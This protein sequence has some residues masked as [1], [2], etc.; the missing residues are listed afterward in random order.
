MLVLSTS[1]IE[2]NKKRFLFFFSANVRECQQTIE[3]FSTTRQRK[4]KRRREKKKKYSYLC[5]IVKKYV[6]GRDQLAG[7]DH[8]VYAALQLR[9]DELVQLRD[10]R[11]LVARLAEPARQD[12]ASDLRRGPDELVLVGER[13]LDAAALE[14]VLLAPGP[15]GLGVE[16]KPVV[17]E[18]DRRRSAHS[19][20]CYSGLPPARAGRR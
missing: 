3:A 12:L 10:Q 14:Q 9:E 6:K 19:R 18:Q 1:E 7:A 15:D 13:E 11:R 4:K 16:Q 17:V 2:N 20:G 8:R 5:H